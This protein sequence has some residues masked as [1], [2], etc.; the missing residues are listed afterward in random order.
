MDSNSRIGNGAMIAGHEARRSSAI[1]KRKKFACVECRQQKSKCDALE[2]APEPC[3][4]CSKKGVS[5]VLQKDY[6]RTYK[7]ARHQFIEQRFKELT[8]SLSALSANELISKI[9]EEHVEILDNKNFTKD[10][11]ELLKQTESDRKITENMLGHL[12]RFTDLGGFNESSDVNL[13]GSAGNPSAFTGMA[14]DQLQSP[15]RSLN[16]IYMNSEDI[17][18]LFQEYATK[19]H[20]F[21]PIVDLSM[22][23]ERIYKL[24]PCLFWV[25]MLIGLRRRVNSTDLM[26]RLSI[27]VKAILAEI[28]ISPIIKYSPAEEDEPILNEASV[29]SVQAFLIYSFWPP[30]TSSLSADTSWNTIGTAM[31]Q[32]I[33]V[34]LNSAAFSNEYASHSELT[35]EKLKTWIAC[36]IVS[37]AIASSFGFPSYVSFDYSV[38]NLTTNS[39]S[40]KFPLAIDQM[41]QMAYFEYQIVNTINSNPGKADAMIGLAEK[42]PLLNVL[43]QQLSQLELKLVE[44]DVDDIRK[45]LLLVSKVHLLTTFLLDSTSDITEMDS[46]KFALIKKEV[47]FETKRGLVKCYNAAIEL[48]KHA[49][50]MWE[51]DPI[52]VKYFPGVFVL[53]IWQ[54]AC[55]ISKLVHSSL[56]TFLNITE[57]KDVYQKAVMMTFNASVLKYDMAY[58]SSGIMRSIWSLYSNMYDSWKADLNDENRIY[59]F[60]L[61][62]AVQSR[63]SVSV[64]FDCLYVLRQKSGMAKLERERERK[65]AYDIEEDD[66]EITLKKIEKKD[67]VNNKEVLGSRSKILGLK[68]PESKARSIIKTIPLDPQPINAT[69]VPTSV[70]LVTTPNSHVSEGGTSTYS[71]NH[72]SLSNG[73]DFTQNKR[74]V[75][76]SPYVKDITSERTEVT[77]SNINN[78]NSVSSAASANSAPAITNNAIP[79]GSLTEQLNVGQN[80]VGAHDISQKEENNQLLNQNLA[81]MIKD[82]PNFVMG[83]WDNWESDLVWKDVDLLMNEFAFDPSV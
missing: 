42:Q 29:Y 14:K 3:T 41:A 25:I 78:K 67:S 54:A 75:T 48:L 12:Q 59:E 43:S 2:K 28:T 33:R 70:S 61:G 47:N 76:T 72:T 35:T 24:S 79:Y 58:R 39:K 80:K 66:E 5:C 40:K 36:N 62:V 7:R 22:G 82:S 17:A 50:R 13:K 20:P 9:K 34:G 73:T 32:A 16:E 74:A 31:F 11:M 69:S 18:E 63:M 19:Y 6:R 49:N 26:A 23:A 51:D 56:S 71:I 46:Y 52:V 21:L 38:I 4:K 37:Q 1:D 83:N 30:L 45:F 64:F 55:I 27:S 77:P 65:E 57:G 53:N 68:D 10:K 44:E 8:E 81:N 60:N 15:P